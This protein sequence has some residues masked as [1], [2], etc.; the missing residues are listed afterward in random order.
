MKATKNNKKHNKNNEN[1][2]NTISKNKNICFVMIPFANHFYF[3]MHL[4]C[5]M[6]HS[7]KKLMFSGFS[8]S[9]S[10]SFNDK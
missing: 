4:I 8:F 1:Y 5:F 10:F 9:L 7:D 2:R 6:V 3:F